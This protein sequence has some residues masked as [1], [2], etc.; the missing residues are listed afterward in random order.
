[1]NKE[2]INKRPSVLDELLDEITPLE[3]RK[4][5]DRMLIAARIADLIK[6]K[7]WTKKYFADEVVRQQPS[8]V[9]KWLSGTHN[10][11]LETLTEISFALGITLAEL[12][13]EKEQALVFKSS[14]AVTGLSGMADR[15]FYGGGPIPS[16]PDGPIPSHPDFNHMTALAVNPGSAGIVDWQEHLTPDKATIGLM[17]VPHHGSHEWQALGNAFWT[18]NIQVLHPKKKR[19]EDHERNYALKA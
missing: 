7:G 19:P 17:T 12:M 3:S 1:M 4:T 5:E 18:G 10:Y 15:R 2:T 8:V 13:R 6:A 16:H 11:T 9:S 14:F